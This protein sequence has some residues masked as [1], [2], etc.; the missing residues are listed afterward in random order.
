L[1]KKTFLNYKCFE[2]KSFI[3]NSKIIEMSA[4]I[5]EYMNDRRKSRRRSSLVASEALKLMNMDSASFNDQSL[6]E[7]E[8]FDRITEQGLKWL[9][10][11]LEDL[12]TKASVVSKLATKT[13]TSLPSSLNVNLEKREND[14]EM[15]SDEQKQFLKSTAISEEDILRILKNKHKELIK[16]SHIISS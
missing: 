14:Y 12:Q 1:K 2:I 4:S 15:L 10:R 13:N 7:L 16:V 6:S 11:K 8:Y 9:E 5:N 3:Q